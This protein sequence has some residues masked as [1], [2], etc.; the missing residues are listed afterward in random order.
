MGLGN[1]VSATLDADGETD[2]YR[3][4]L[5]SPTRLYFDSLT[6]D[7]AKVWSLLGPRGYEISSRAFSRSDGTDLSGNAILALPAGNYQLRVEGS[8]GAYGFRLIDVAAAIPFTPGSAPRSEGQRVGTA[9]V[10]P[11]GIRWG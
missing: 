8:T 3:F 7:S 11:G 1:D 6:F 9:G 10:G 2:L 4:T 5:A